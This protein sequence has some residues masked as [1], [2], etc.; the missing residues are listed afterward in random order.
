MQ[1]SSNVNS[2]TQQ[3][4]SY[5]SY[6]TPI[7]RQSFSFQ[8]ATFRLEN[9]LLFLANG[10]QLVRR[11]QIHK[12]NSNIHMTSK[13]PIQSGRW[14]TLIRSFQDVA[15]CQWLRNVLF[16]QLIWGTLGQDLQLNGLVDTVTTCYDIRNADGKWIPSRSNKPPCPTN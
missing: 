1:I 5:S 12:I 2:T 6:P 15:K 11:S 10:Q 9:H 4:L 13:S 8:V 7:P 14:S 3:S 16:E